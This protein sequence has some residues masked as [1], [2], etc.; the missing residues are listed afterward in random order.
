M[1][2]DFSSGETA[3]SMRALGNQE[4]SMESV[5]SLIKRVSYVLENGKTAGKRGGFPECN[6][7]LMNFINVLA[8]NEIN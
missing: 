3:A 6:F 8:L 4:S 7:S 5:N 1:D 2:K